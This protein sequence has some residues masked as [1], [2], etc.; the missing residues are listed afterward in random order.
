[1][2]GRA[3]PDSVRRVKPPNTT[4]PN[5]LAALPSSQYATLLEVVLG[6]EL[7]LASLLVAA[8]PSITL[9]AFAPSMV[10][11]LRR[12]CVDFHRTDCRAD[13]RGEDRV[14][15]TA[16]RIGDC[17]LRHGLQVKRRRDSRGAAVRSCGSTWNIE[18][19]AT[20]TSWGGRSSGSPH[21]I[22][23]GLSV[24]RWPAAGKTTPSMNPAYG[25]L[26]GGSDDVR[27]TQARKVRQTAS[28][29]R[30]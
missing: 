2:D 26:T 23:F 5:T 10:A 25:P 14:A 3:Y 7:D 4:M 16:D 1:M 27:P 12:G 24:V 11:L 15:E 29:H 13:G 8:S 17:E 30:T 19:M 9:S 18:A 6:K 21:V 20:I 28:H 22:D